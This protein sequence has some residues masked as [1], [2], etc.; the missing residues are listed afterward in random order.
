[1]AMHEDKLRHPEYSKVV[2]L[3]REN[4]KKALNHNVPDSL[5]IEFAE[6]YLRSFKLSFQGIRSH[7][8]LKY[9]P[10]WLLWLSDNDYRE[11]CR[12]VMNENLDG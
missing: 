5:V 8:K 9:F 12:E 4:L 11:C 2:E 7:I 10:H 1:M 3:R 6:N